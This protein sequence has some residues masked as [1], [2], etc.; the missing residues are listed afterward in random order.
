VH[1][2]NWLI[3]LHE[4]S[5]QR[6]V[7]P[8]VDDRHIRRDFWYLAFTIEVQLRIAISRPLLR[9]TQ[10]AVEAEEV[11]VWGQPRQVTDS[12]PSE[13]TELKGKSGWNM[14]PGPF[15]VVEF[16]PAE[17]SAR[18]SG[19]D[20][21]GSKHRR[22]LLQFIAQCIRCVSPGE[23]IGVSSYSPHEGTNKLVKPIF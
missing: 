20:K 17:E 1:E 10:E 18:H 16:V 12:D 19:L 2:G 6:I 8:A 9:E 14:L 23:C 15:E 11:R 3:V 13:D 5:R 4:K 7:E 22:T 21:A